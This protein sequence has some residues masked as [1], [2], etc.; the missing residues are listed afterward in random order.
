MTSRIMSA[1][2]CAVAGA[3]FGWAIGFT[4]MPFVKCE[5]ICLKSKFSKTAATALRKV[6]TSVNHIADMLE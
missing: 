4:T 2:K 5:N 3:V 6:S 1:V